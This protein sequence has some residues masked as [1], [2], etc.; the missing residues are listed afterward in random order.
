VFCDN[1]LKEKIDSPLPHIP[2]PF[3]SNYKDTYLSAPGNALSS[4]I[5]CNATINKLSA[6]ASSNKGEKVSSLNLYLGV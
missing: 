4:A 6:G 3:A 1:F 2:S 5:H